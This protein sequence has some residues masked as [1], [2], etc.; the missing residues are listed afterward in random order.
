MAPHYLILLPIPF[1]ALGGVCVWAGRKELA[2]GRASKQWPPVMGTVQSMTPIH[3]GV[4]GDHGG[5]LRWQ[6][7]VRYFYEVEGK[8]H[9]G[10]WKTPAT[11]SVRFERRCE[12]LR[13]GGPIRVHV[14]PANPHCSVV[15]PGLTLARLMPTLAGLAFILLSTTVTAA[16]LLSHAAH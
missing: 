10:D 16:V 4:H 3:Q 11:D 13:E 15:E 6:Y 2:L 1:I 8:R 12:T 14:D 9:W 7:Y 5:E